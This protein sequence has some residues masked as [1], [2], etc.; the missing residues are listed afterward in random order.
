MSRE[1]VFNLLALVYGSKTLIKG[2]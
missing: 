2:V 1:D